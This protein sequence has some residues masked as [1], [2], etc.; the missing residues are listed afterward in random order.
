MNLPKPK[1]NTQ[2]I[3]ITLIDDGVVS[4]FNFP[5]LSGFRTRISELS[6][7]YKLPL[8][9][10]QK[11]GVNKFGNTFV[12]TEHVL[13]DDNKELAKNIYLKIAKQ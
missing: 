5:T 12:F 10:I 8:T 1:T 7:F 3:L 2:E 4:L 13:S 6:N 9:H 11:T